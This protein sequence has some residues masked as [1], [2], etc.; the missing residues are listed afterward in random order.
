MVDFLSYN[1]LIET[2]ISSSQ[3]ATLPMTDTNFNVFKG[4]KTVIDFKIR[5]QDTQVID[6]TDK[7]LVINVFNYETGGFEFYKYLEITDPIRGLARA[8]FE[9]VDTIDLS[10]AYYYYSLVSIDDD[11][12]EPYYIDGV[13]NVLS[14]FELVDGVMPSPIKSISVTPENFTP[15]TDPLD[16]DTTMWVAGPFKGDSNKYRDDGLHTVVFYLDDFSGQ[17]S[18]EISLNDQPLPDDWSKI[19]L[20]ELTPW[21]VYDQYTGI[22]PFNFKA[23]AKWVRFKYVEEPTPQGTVTKIMYRN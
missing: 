22:E 15:T 18:V 19:W 1:Q 16:I 13:G 7:V 5:S 21:K 17:V 20:D 4:S 11:T 6:L 23:N 10:P 8:T 9:I 14:Y 3:P 2:T 12:P